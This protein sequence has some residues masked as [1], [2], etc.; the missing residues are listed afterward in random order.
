[1]AAGQFQ[2]PC[3]CPSGRKLGFLA[4]NHYA[5]HSGR[6]LRHDAENTELTAHG[7]QSIDSGYALAR[8]ELERGILHVDADEGGS[9][10]DRLLIRHL[11][12]VGHG[13]I[14]RLIRKGNVR[15]NRKR[16]KP[17]SR[18]QAGDEIF[19]PASLRQPQQS[20]AEGQLPATLLRRVA[21]T[22]VLFEDE[23]LLVVNKPAGLVVHGGSGHEAGLIEALKELRGLSDLRLAHRLDRD[24]SGVLLLAKSLGALRRL[25]ESFRERDMQKSYLALVAG[26]PYAAAG[27]MRSKLAK[28]VVQGG[29]RMVVDAES[30]KEAVTDYQ[31]MIEYERDG[32]RY[33]LLAL[34]PHSGRTHQ[35]RVQLQ[36][37]GHAILGDGKYADKEALAAYRAKGGRGLMLHAWRLRFE[38][39]VSH[40]SMELKAPWP[41]SWQPFLNMRQ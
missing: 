26:H 36:G 14:S 12:D 34:N 40:A 21:E 28:G 23:W 9:R 4:S 5:R 11:G 31:V 6:A 22:P 2:S 8:I 38:H 32:F 29:E 37:E 13:L 18:V 10:L 20:P 41:E 1:M 39:P 16:A 19:L 25:T 33:A 17:E 3:L 24:T 27:R 35:L 7:G 15:I 30:G